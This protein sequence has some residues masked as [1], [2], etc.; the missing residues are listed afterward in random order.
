M[1]SSPV[2]SR[3][4][5]F[6]ADDGIEYFVGLAVSDGQS[7]SVKVLDAKSALAEE[8]AFTGELKTINKLLSPLAASEVGTIRCIGLNYK[9]HAT[10]LGLSLPK[11]PE[12]FMKTATC[13]TGPNDTVFIPS[14]VTKVDPEVELAVL[15]GK[16]CKNVTVS[17]ALDYVLGYT[18]ANDI[19]ARCLQDQ[20]LQWGYCKG[21]DGFCPLGPALVSAK[22][23]PDPSKLSVKTVLDG[24]TMQQSTTDNFI[25]SVAEIVSHLSKGT[26][27]NKG[28][29]ILT[30]TPAGIGHGRNPPIY[31]NEE[32]TLR[33]WISHGLGTLTNAV[34][35]E[36]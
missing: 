6:I 14:I 30:G 3:L 10:E 32:S 8:A 21:F 26:T 16:D 12:V 4:V 28:T 1:S 25:F 18:V 20:M 5:R 27:L 23:I 13:I 34:R 29:I 17:E 7:V 19:T 11:M 36:R 31:L 22:A 2:W 24:V 9:D 15:I 33:I 35:W